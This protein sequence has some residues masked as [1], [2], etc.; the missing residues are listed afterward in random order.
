MVLY[1]K[2]AQIGF[3]KNSYAFKFLFVA[4]IGIHIP[5]IGLLFFVLYGSQNIS[6]NMILVFALVMTLTATI[7]TLFI[8]KRL[9][10]PIEVASKAL[11]DYRTDRVFSDL[12]LN[13]TDE[14][15]LLMRNIHESIQDNE[16][17]IKDKQDM[18]YL[19]SHDLRTFAG[20]P[21]AIATL[22]LNENPSAGIKELAEL[23]VESSKQ[24]LVYIE[25]FIK[26]LKDQDQ[27]IKKTEEKNRISPAEL[28]ASVTELATQS[29]NKKNIKLISEI[30]VSEVFLKIDQD[31][32]LSVLSNLVNNAIKFSFPDSEIH[33][34][35]YLEAKKIIFTVSDS[36]IGFDSNQKEALFQKFTKEGRLGTS[37]EP[38]TG[39]GLYLSKNSIEKQ[40]GTLTAISDT[41]KGAT[42]T[43]ILDA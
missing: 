23:I 40:G 11:N 42:F 41:G 20:N 39:I 34:R 36:G 27:F 28:I 32:L 1:K 33:V 25:N 12:P 30:E 6:P 37:N 38:S 9:I 35:I 19:L 29:L 3:L 8:L 17:F 5:L 4:F 7:L 2:L 24:Q 16:T 13:F 26:V 31:S 14:A 18:V 21:Q 10:K 22:I 15:G 43:I